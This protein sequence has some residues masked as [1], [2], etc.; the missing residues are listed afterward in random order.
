ML[1]PEA[2]N[3]LYNAF[4]SVKSLPITSPVDFI[5]GPNVVSTE[6]SFAN[7]NTGAFTYTS[8]SSG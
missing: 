3:P 4:S 1:I 8:F 7:E 5:S 2:T 6:R